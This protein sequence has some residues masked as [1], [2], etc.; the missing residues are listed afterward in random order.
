MKY[1]PCKTPR[2]HRI[3]RENTSQILPLQTQV[4]FKKIGLVKSNLGT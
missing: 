3:K 4:S 2:N 1:D